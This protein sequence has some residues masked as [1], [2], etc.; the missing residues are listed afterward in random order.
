[1]HLNNNV[2]NMQINT[3]SII[4]REHD[5]TN[6]RYVCTNCNVILKVQSVKMKPTKHFCNKER[7]RVESREHTRDSTRDFVLTVPKNK[8][9]QKSA[10]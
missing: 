2:V 1:M 6:T 3:F 8:R 9:M 10:V 4:N 5:R 7:K